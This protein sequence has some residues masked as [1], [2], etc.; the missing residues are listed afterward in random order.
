MPKLFAVVLAVAWLMLS[1]QGMAEE[2]AEHGGGSRSWL[3]LNSFQSGQ[4]LAID[5][6]TGQIERKIAV[7]D[8]SGIIGF[9]VSSDGKRLFIADG[10]AKSRLRI[11]DAASGQQI[12]EHRFEHRALLPGRKPTIHL[13]AD[14]R[15]LLIST[16]DYAADA[17]GIRIFDVENGSFLPVGLRGRGCDNGKFASAR[18]GVL[19]ELCANVLRELSMSA[20]AP[21]DSAETAKID[22]GIESPAALSF[23]PDG[24]DLYVLGEIEADGSWSLSHW[25]RGGTF[26]I[27][28]DL[29]K[30]LNITDEIS[31]PRGRAV[32]ALALSPD[33]TR[34]A[35]SAGPHLWLLDRKSLR[36][37]DRQT[38]GAIVGSLVFTDDGGELLAMQAQPGGG[39]ELARI[40][41]STGKIDRTPLGNLGMRFADSPA[42]FRLAPA[43]AP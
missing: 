14:G 2:G 41:V 37:T 43:P 5:P 20:S 8:G 27:E 17:K 39:G 21:G 35:V 34:L 42:V 38:L 3:Y 15:W 12:A 10:D 22:T 23:S 4:L 18:N 11:L 40:S 36:V 16:Y 28:H 25:Q 13:T 24:K 19:I 33:G 26:S 9:A 29:R 1:P 32:P 6:A 31:D 30:L 7:K